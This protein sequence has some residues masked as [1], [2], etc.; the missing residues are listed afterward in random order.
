MHIYAP[1]LSAAAPLVVSVGGAAPLAAAWS[2]TRA[3]VSGPGGCMRAGKRAYVPTE[4]REKEGT[5]AV[6]LALVRAAVTYYVCAGIC[7]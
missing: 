4:N 7:Y 5:H 3:A 2:D 1:H 6:Y